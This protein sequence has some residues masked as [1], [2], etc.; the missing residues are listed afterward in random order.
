MSQLT[1]GELEARLS[2]I[3]A[4][5]SST[6]QLTLR[7]GVGNVGWFSNS[8]NNM[9]QSEWVEIQLPE[10]TTIDQIVLVPVLWNDAEHGPQAD[11]F[12]E[13][14]RI[15][16]GRTGDSEGEEIAR[17][18]PEDRFL[19][20]V[21]PLVIQFPSTTV[22]WVRVQ[23]T[24][25]SQHAR[26]DGRHRFKLSEIMIFSGA[27][28]VALR[29]PVRVS[30][31]VK[32]WGEAAIYKEALVD[33]LTPYLM[34]AAGSEKSNPYMVTSGKAGVPYLIVIDLEEQQVVKGIR[35]HGADVNEYIPQINPTDF[36]MPTR[37]TV[38]ASN[39][40]DFA[41]PIPLLQ[42]TRDSIYQAGNILEWSV[43]DTECRYVRISIPKDAWPLDAGNTQRY[44]SLAEI[45]IISEGRNVAKG[46]AVEIYP[47]KRIRNYYVPSL[48]DGL[49]HFGTILPTRD[50]ME[51]LARRHD[52][53]VERPNIATELNRKYNLQKA[54]LIRMSWLA[55]LLAAGIA[56]ALLIGRL[57]Q[58]R[59][60]LKTRERIAANLHDELSAN[61]HA[62]AL[63]GEMA[64]NHIQTPSKLEG[65]IERIQNLSKSSRNA[66]R[67]C[68]NML[69]ANTIGEDLPK[70]MHYI[71]ER[72]LVDTRHELTF[73]GQSYLQKLP[74]R[75]R[76]DLFLF[77]KESLTN[78][79]RHA[80]AQACSTHLIASSDRIQL[81]V[82]DNGFGTTVTPPSLKRRARFLR[83]RIECETPEGGG[84]RI[85]LSLKPRWRWGGRKLPQK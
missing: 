53:E 67:H 63:L 57:L 41:H 39:Q 20:R 36:G 2:E 33:G 21:A 26:E 34:D 16:A 1:V 40:R 8:P 42:Y 3:D 56:F 10:E 50:W 17:L 31:V 28:N 75:T 72:L 64:K 14:F 52:L 62:L 84:T 44:I 79:A 12:P 22:S 51:Q 4:E 48:T 7:S 49:N 81:T 19:P 9:P 73:E 59:A 78:I 24:Q 69:K 77:Y 15:L 27:R 37:F 23:P 29:S 30:S 65:I 6:A 58:M 47:K 76:N 68:T 5:L 46:K 60:V 38:E 71:A 43:S 70:E 32:G 61:L 54:N 66:A 13:A 85:T 11:G 25:L 35:I 80:E 74:T 55:A 83:A 18:E 45:E 82:T